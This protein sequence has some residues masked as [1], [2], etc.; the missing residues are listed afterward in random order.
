MRDPVGTFRVDGELPGI[1]L[2]KERQA[3][4][5]IDAQASDE[6]P[7]Q[8]GHRKTRSVKASRTQRS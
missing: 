3:Q 1:G 6:K 2:R 8:R 4:E 7:D 5:R